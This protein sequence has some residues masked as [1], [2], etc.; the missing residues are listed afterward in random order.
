MARSWVEFR[1]IPGY[2]V[3]VLRL[4]GLPSLYPGPREGPRI[5]PESSLKLL[6]L[7]SKVSGPR[8]HPVAHQSSSFLYLDDRKRTHKWQ[9]DVAILT[10]ASPSPSGRLCPPSPSSN[11]W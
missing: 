10:G 6:N 9:N 11:R 3:T 7:I 8:H 1:R 5:A 2:I 4:L